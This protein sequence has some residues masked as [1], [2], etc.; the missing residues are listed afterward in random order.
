MRSPFTDRR[1][2]I[3]PRSLRELIAA[4]AAQENDEK[5]RRRPRKVI[6]TRRVT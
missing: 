6:S 4:E 1:E 3:L 5:R 2:D